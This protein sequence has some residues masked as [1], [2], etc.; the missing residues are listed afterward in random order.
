MLWGETG[1]KNRHETRSVSSCPWTAERIEGGA[2]VAQGDAHGHPS[3]IP[4]SS[5][6]EITH[7]WER[8]RIQGVWTAVRGSIVE[9]AVHR[10]SDYEVP[11]TVEPVTSRFGNRPFR[12]SRL[13][14]A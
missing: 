1:L 14:L 10:S 12:E 8:L 6:T 11:A 2:Q 7:S 9:P 4:A 13:D 3:E 5:L